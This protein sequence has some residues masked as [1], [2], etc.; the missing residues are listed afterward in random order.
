M[1]KQVLRIKK[2]ISENLMNFSAKTFHIDDYFY[3]KIPTEGGENGL[4][5][6]KWHLGNFLFDFYFG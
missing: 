4:T 5:K 1:I 3:V 2:E 6:A